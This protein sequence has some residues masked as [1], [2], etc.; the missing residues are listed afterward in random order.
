MKK[1]TK[2]KQSLFI[3][4]FAVMIIA[5]F[6][7]TNSGN[8][9]SVISINTGMDVSRGKEDVTQYRLT[10]SADNMT[11]I[12]KTFTSESLSLTLQQ[13]DNRLFLLEALD[14]TGKTLYMDSKT[15]DLRAGSTLVINFEL[16]EIIIDEP[17][18]KILKTYYTSP[19]VT[20]EESQ[21]EGYKLRYAKSEDGLE[22]AKE[23]SCN[24]NSYKFEELEAENTY[25]WQYCTLGTTDWSSPA[26]LT[27]KKI[28]ITDN[29][30][31]DNAYDLLYLSE[32]IDNYSS[33]LDYKFVLMTDIDME[34]LPEGIEF[35]P[36]G[37]NSYPFKG[38]F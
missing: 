36:I 12:V 19:T 20:W 8:E 21:G 34:D 33:F 3:L 4:F 35:N 11:T 26:T 16:I 29:N 6:S 13:G 37:N 1:N 10:I 30:P 38:T 31:I 5:A 32:N 14:K 23:I 15:A 2:H 22:S 24:T 25:Y 9:L 18:K 28:S 27:I 17:V 7:C